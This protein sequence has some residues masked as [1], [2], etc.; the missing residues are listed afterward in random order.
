[1][2]QYLTQ[3]EWRFIQKAI[4]RH[5]FPALLLDVGGGDGR[6]A[7]RLSSLGVHSIILEYDPLPIQELIARGW[8]EP[9]VLGDGNHLPFK[10]DSFDVVMV[11]EVSACTARS[12]LT[13]F[14]AQVHQVLKPKGWML[15][16]T[17]NVVSMIGLE[18][19]IRSSK[20]HSTSGA[21]THSYWEVRRT[22]QE[23][24]FDIL[25][26]HGFRWIPANRESQNRFI[27]LCGYLERLLFLERLPYFAPW[28]FWVVRNM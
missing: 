14:L 11:I 1:M 22:L 15:L 28:I 18:R 9:V 7:V 2:G 24:G 27:P 13:G 5:G 16:T 26:S 23:S 10:D 12:H 8:C 17:H 4:E 25:E 19:L 21:Y 6:F 3:Q 20:Y